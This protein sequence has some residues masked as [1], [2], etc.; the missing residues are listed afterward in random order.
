MRLAVDP[1]DAEAKAAQLSAIS[2]QLS[3]AAE[4]DSMRRVAALQEQ[5][6][7]SEAE[8]AARAKAHDLAAGFPARIAAQ[9]KLFAKLLTNLEAVAELAGQIEQ[10][11]RALDTDIR[12]LPG[13][14]RR[15]G[16]IAGVARTFMLAHPL[17]PVLQALSRTK[18]LEPFVQVKVP[19]PVD[20]NPSI[21][22]SHKEAAER[23]AAIATTA[24]GVFADTAQQVKNRIDDLL[25]PAPVRSS[26]AAI[27]YGSPKEPS[28]VDVLAY[29][30][31][32]QIAARRKQR[33]LDAAKPI[34]R[35]AEGL[36]EL[37]R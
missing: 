2:N 12:T 26:G 17:R 6:R 27:I 4:R 11:Q 25:G 36:V 32:P 16:M 3:L 14:H 33:A 21:G 10:T 28:S 20:K 24:E 9:G 19:A 29:D 31:R 22:E 35:N 7:L 30:D 18:F 23:I 37:A 5:A 8:N 1:G 15:V 13:D 34:Q